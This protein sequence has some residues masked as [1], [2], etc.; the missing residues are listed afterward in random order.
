LW[1][2]ELLEIW[3][4]PVLGLEGWPDEGVEVTP[5]LP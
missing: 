4:D 2:A 3:A 1:K 5:E